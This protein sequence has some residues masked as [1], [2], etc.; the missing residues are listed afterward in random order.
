MK[1]IWIRSAMVMGAL[2]IA[3]SLVAQITTS[4]ITGTVM[5]SSGAALPGASVTI[6]NLAQGI[7]RTAT[8][9]SVGD[10]LI[11]GLPA[12]TYS[13]TVSAQGFAPYQATG[14]ILQAAQDIHEN[15]SLT[16]G[17]V[18]SK[19]NVVGTNIGQ[20]QTENA[21]L[22][23]TVTSRQ[24]TELEL[25]G[26]QFTQLIA[27]MPGV[28]NMSGQD[29]GAVG[30]TAETSYTINGGRA[31]YNNWEID[32]VSNVDTG[33]GGSLNVTFPS[34][35]AIGETRV[36]TSNYGAQYGQNGSGT[37]VVSLKSGTDRFHGDLY[38][39]NRNDVF[40]SRNFF[41]SN[42]GSYKKN[43]FGY[44][45]GGPFYIPGH[46]N[47]S[48]SKT[49]F[50]W[51]EEW[52]RQIAP[53]TF[54]LQVPSTQERQGNFSDVC[55]NVNTGSF[56]DC[57]T[58]PATGTYF[59]GN[60]VTIDPNAQDLMTAYISP[61]N[62]GSG[63]LSFFQANP[64]YPTTWREELVRVDQNIAPKVRAM[65]HYIHDSW[66]QVVPSTMWATGSFPTVNTDFVS[67][68]ANLV[69]ELTVAAS[70]TLLNQFIFGYSV[71]HIILRNTG[72]WQIPSNFTM[73]G[74]YKNGFSGILPSVDICC[75]AQDNGGSGFAME[76]NSPVPGQPNFNSNPVYSFRESLSKIAGPHNLTFGFDALARQKN[77]MAQPAPASDNG[78]LTFTNTSA[79]TTGNAWADFLTGRVAEYEQVSNRLKYYTRG[80]SFTPYVQ[81]D[82][83]ISHHLT[84]NLG[85]RAE[86][87]RTWNMK[88]DIESSFSPASYSAAAAPQIDLTGAITGVPGALIPGI[89]NQFDGINICGVGGFPA[90]CMK[91]HLFNPAPRFGFAWD[92]S[93]SGAWA[94]RG[95]YGI[96]FEQMNGNEVNAES[97][98]GTPPK[99]LTSAVYN[100]VGYTHIG[101]ATPANFPITATELQNQERWPNVQQWNLDVERNIGAHTVVSVAYVGSKGTHLADVRDGNQ[102]SPT[103]S[104]QN[105]FGP[106]QPITPA[107][108][109]SLAVNGQP[110]TGQALMNLSVACGVTSPVAYRPFYGLNDLQLLETEANSDYNALQIYIR[111]TVGR[112]NFSLA[113][114]YSH[115][116]DDASDRFDNLFRNS[117]NLAQNY[118][119]SNYDQRHNLSASYVYAL[120][121]FG[122]QSSWLLKNTLGGWQISGIT[123]FETGTP[124]TI[125]NGIYSDNDGVGNGYGTGSYPDI[126]GNINAAPPETNVPG[127]IGPLLFN[128]GAFCAPQGLTFGNAGRNILRNPDISNWNMGLFKSIPIHGEQVH[129]QFR[130]EA[131]N[132]FNHSQLY[133]TVPTT[134]GNVITTGCYAGANNSA[135]DPSCIAGSTFLHADAAHNPRILQ[136]GLKLIF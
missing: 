108:C 35:D 100:V 116:L 52:R 87:I 69:G 136:L 27:L 41:A 130:A 123:T 8:T 46:Y 47:T 110:V 102:I 51:S 2:S 120:P 32:G 26:R 38:E 77:E 12:G 37:M 25:N 111:K 65:V 56:A 31:V 124:I 131:F 80:K 13:L 134:T 55:P 70:P 99:T 28:S 135:G 16:V 113:Y 126:C 68:G 17:A 21:Q 24:I 22:G 94:I 54:D 15:V 60:Q 36:L 122:S 92:P 61:P 112:L 45:F 105:P 75:N 40:N 107:I 72:P 76:P 129:L 104:S 6:A 85:F 20:V 98:E 74:I 42:V 34:V 49:F 84:F 59:P 66:H 44:T 19:V 127:V 30:P 53:N 109:G 29:E 82:W 132:T 64:S 81:D 86:L 62:F 128:P 106:G 101:S 121:F 67:P 50:F 18:T 63:A 71:N 1:A 23:G 48:K 95:G 14:I 11:S 93:G 125:A 43:D 9:N 88:Y 4:S 90:A 91:G 117:Y 118:A 7:S 79:V 115:S 58:N 96:F 119:S 103:P 5:D 33:A 10:Y 3:L 89:G 78:L 39:F 57:P 83:H 133:V 97:L 114:T 73:T